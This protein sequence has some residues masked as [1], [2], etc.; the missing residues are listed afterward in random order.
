MADRLDS[1]VA[2]LSEERMDIDK[3]HT[4]HLKLISTQM[5]LE[6]IQF[7]L[8]EKMKH[9]LQ[10]I[11]RGTRHYSRKVRSLKSTRKLVNRNEKEKL[12]KYI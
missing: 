3:V 12:R 4:R 11:K 1:V 9:C 8:K 5:M 7:S 6:T 10:D 2:R